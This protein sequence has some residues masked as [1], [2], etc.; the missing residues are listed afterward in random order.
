MPSQYIKCDTCGKTLG[1]EQV[2]KD[3]HVGVGDTPALLKAAESFGWRVQGDMHTCPTCVQEQEG[4][5][6]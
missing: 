3:R 2:I 6:K 1:A 5:E 4:K